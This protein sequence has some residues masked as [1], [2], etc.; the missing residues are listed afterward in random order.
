[1]CSWR[2]SFSRVNSSQFQIERKWRY[3][4]VRGC[5]SIQR[6]QSS[7]QIANEK[8]K[9]MREKERENGG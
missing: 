3:W 2:L 5:A 8:K 7:I 9:T 4:H 6:L 1:M